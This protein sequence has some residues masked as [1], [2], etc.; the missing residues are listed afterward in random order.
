M[1]EPPA[2]LEPAN[3][4]M[5]HTAT[6]EVIH[7]RY[8]RLYFDPPPSVATLRD[9]LVRAKVPWVKANMTARRG[10]GP[11]YFHVAAADRFLRRRAGLA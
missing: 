11:L 7:Q 3:R 9:W 5:A 4:R 1:P 8:A 10:G 6:A 2:D